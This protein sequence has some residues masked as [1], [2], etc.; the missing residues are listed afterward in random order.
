MLHLSELLIWGS[1]W[2]R[3]F[4]FHRLILLLLSMIM[5]V[6]LLLLLLSLFISLVRHA[7]G[8]RRAERCGHI[9]RL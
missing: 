9:N 7:A 2:G 4:R 6:C 5:I 1:T 3:G 8:R